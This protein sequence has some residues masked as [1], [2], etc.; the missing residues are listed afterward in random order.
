MTIH[1]YV[2]T[3]STTHGPI[4]DSGKADSIDAATTSA[5]RAAKRIHRYLYSTSVTIYYYDDNLKLLY[6]EQSSNP[7]VRRSWHQVTA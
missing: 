6:K 5:R 4:L 1:Y 2:R 7:S 3:G